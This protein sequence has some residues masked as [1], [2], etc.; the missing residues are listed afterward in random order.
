MDQ[1]KP[2][3]DGLKK[4]G[5]WVACGA[6]AV[7]GV[8]ISFLATSSVQT[9]ADKYR[10]EIGSAFTSAQGLS[11]VD[12]K[13]GLTGVTENVST[14]SGTVFPNQ[15]TLDEM[16]RLTDE[17]KI[18]AREAWEYQYSQQQRLLVFP[19]DLSDNVRNAFRR[20]LPIESKLPR[21]S[22]IKA[23]Q[24]VRIEFRSAYGDYIRKRLPQLAEMIGAHWNPTAQAAAT[25]STGSV[26][27]GLGATG[28]GSGPGGAAGPMTSPMGGV[29]GAT[30]AGTGDESVVDDRPE[31]VRWNPANQ[32]FWLAA[33]TQF[34]GRNG[35]TSSA[36]QPT[37]H[38]VM[39][40]QEDLWVLEAVFSVIKGV[41]GD[42]DANDLADIKQV[43]H[44]LVGAS[45]GTIG[46][47]SALDAGSSA[48]GGS[49]QGPGSMDS[50]MMMMQGSAMPGSGGPRGPSGGNSRN[51][52]AAADVSDPANLRYVD[53]DFEPLSASDFFKSLKAT[54]PDDAYLQVAKRIPVRL[55]FQMKESALI[56]LLAQ[57]AN[58]DP[59]IEV[60]Q[61]RINRHKPE[62]GSLSGAGGGSGTGMSMSGGAPTGPT[63][64]SVGG[65]GGQSAAEGTMGAGGSGPGGRGAA[66]AASAP[67]E[68]T[69]V[70]GVEIYGVVYIFNP[71]PTGTD[72]S[73]ILKLVHPPADQAADRRVPAVAVSGN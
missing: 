43:D 15:S 57:C 10:Q 28:M 68:D 27:S 73:N 41:N 70:V 49:P 61:V 12:P 24:E 26:S 8:V 17:A 25:G 60:H 71:V 37:T 64:V 6:V 29:V 44:I 50:R 7:L 31:V 65:A 51:S 5:F 45:A 69:G 62:A 53:R 21:Y 72:E 63:S 40:L 18:A 35:N 22:E 20:L 36:N 9:Q 23:D 58:S 3:L 47:T 56:N 16:D 4:H 38:Q 19:A 42:A 55:G 66:S 54:T 11:G 67:S 59:P 2:I 14:S 34:Q 30:G 1:L 39:Y 52:P 13:E 46:S 48:G 33:S 32:G